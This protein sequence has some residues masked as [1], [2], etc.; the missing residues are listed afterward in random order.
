MS[1]SMVSLVSVLHALAAARRI[2]ND[3][4]WVHFCRLARLQSEAIRIE[5]RV[6]PG[7]QLTKLLTSAVLNLCLPK[8]LE[9]S[10]NS[11]GKKQPNVAFC[12][13]A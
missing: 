13:A 3:V 8:W 12:Q 5:Q 7:Q 11:N 6:K 2:F 1:R 9:E 10:C 4:S